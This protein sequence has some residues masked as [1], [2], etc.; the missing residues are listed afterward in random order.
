MVER[1]ENFIR[2]YVFIFYFFF[3]NELLSDYVLTHHR[4]ALFISAS[5][6]DLI[7]YAATN[8]P[9]DLIAFHIIVPIILYENQRTSSF[10]ILRS[11]PRFS[12]SALLKSDACG[13]WSLLDGRSMTKEQLQNPEDAIGKDEGEWYWLGTWEIDKSQPRIDSEGWQYAKSFDEPEDMWAEFPSTSTVRCV[14]RR[15]WARLMKRSR[16]GPTDEDDYVAKAKAIVSDVGKEA[17]R[18][19]LSI[20]D[21]LERFTQAIA[22]LK[23]GIES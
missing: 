18:N 22:I 8:Q 21:E 11:T 5:L 10:Q 20:S 23:D 17:M 15:K 19:G 1:K 2:M 7:N 3:V 6:G 9:Y 16:N 13:P 4:Y 12:A 14:R